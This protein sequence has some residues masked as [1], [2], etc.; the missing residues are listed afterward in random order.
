M[1]TDK[2]FLLL[3]VHKKKTLSYSA[4]SENPPDCRSH[5]RE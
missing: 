3:F 4:A 2:V 1:P 5:I